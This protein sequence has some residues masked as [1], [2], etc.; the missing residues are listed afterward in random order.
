MEGQVVK[1]EG[2]ILSDLCQQLHLI[3]NGV[4]IQIKHWL[5]KDQLSRMSTSES[6]DS[7]YQF[8]LVEAY[9]QLCKSLPSQLL[10]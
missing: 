10:C 3:L 1:L 7:N 6:E 2:P 8:K 5:S 4:E 9:L